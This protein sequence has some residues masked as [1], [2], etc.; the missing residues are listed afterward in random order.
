MARPVFVLDGSTI[1]DAFWRACSSRARR[2]W[3]IAPRPSCSS[4]AATYPVAACNPTA[5]YSTCRVSVRRQAFARC[6][7]SICL[8]DCLG[9]EGPSLSQPPS[10]SIWSQLLSLRMR[11]RCLAL[12]C[13]AGVSATPTTVAAAATTPTSAASTAQRPWGDAVFQRLSTFPVFENST[14][15]TNVTVAEITAALDAGLTHLDTGVSVAWGATSCC[16]ATLARGANAGSARPQS[17]STSCL[18]PRNTLAGAQGVVAGRRDD[19][20]HACHGT[21]GPATGFSRDRR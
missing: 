20:C 18:T 4:S 13:V 10:P 17:C 2:T 8:V 15:P 16:C 6:S 5:L 21:F 14:D 3:R 12:L 9:R 1:I 11:R 7:P 19:D